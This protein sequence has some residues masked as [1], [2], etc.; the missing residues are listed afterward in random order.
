MA[1]SEIFVPIRINSPTLTFNFSGFEKWGTER[2]SLSCKIRSSFIFAVL[3]LI[4]P[5]VPLIGKKISNCA[6][7]LKLVTY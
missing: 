7:V 2:I 1:A 4:A 3:V 6:R 5:N